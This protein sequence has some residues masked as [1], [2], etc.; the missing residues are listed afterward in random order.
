MMESIAYFMV[1]A[2]GQTGVRA[3][4]QAARRERRGAFIG[5]RAM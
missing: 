3:A 2:G 5:G 1:D 4:G